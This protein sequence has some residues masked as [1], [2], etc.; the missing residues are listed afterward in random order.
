MKNL[1]IVLLMLCVFAFSLFAF[2]ADPQAAA[3]VPSWV[4]TVLAFL[5]GMPY[6]G[7][8]LTGLLK[9]A[10]LA[11]AIMT[12][13]STCAMAILALLQGVSQW[14]GLVKIQAALAWVEAN[15]MPWLKYL[16]MYNVQKK[17]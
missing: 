10:V 12:A 2:G 7:P 16:S 17:Q 9:W 4:A 5:Q 13:I 11:S 8:F 3:E 14:A 15:V 1:K 6:V